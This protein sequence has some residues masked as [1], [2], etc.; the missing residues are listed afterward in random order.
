MPRFKFKEY[1]LE[2]IDGTEIDESNNK[3]TSKEHK[4]N[5]ANAKENMDINENN[6][7][8]SNDNDSTTHQRGFKINIKVCRLELEIVNKLHDKPH[9]VVLNTLLDY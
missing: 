9:N 8:D 6:N 5:S 4:F 2:T 3:I 1:L 7:F